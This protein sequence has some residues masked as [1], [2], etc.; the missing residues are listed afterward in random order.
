[1]RRS[2][3]KCYAFAKYFETAPA[4]VWLDLDVGDWNLIIEMESITNQLAQFRFGEVQKD[5]VASSYALLFPKML[6]LS[7]EL[8]ALDCVVLG[9]P[10][11]MGNEFSQ[12]RTAENVRDFSLLVVNVVESVCESNWHFV[13][14]MKTS[15]SKPCY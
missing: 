3:Y 15:R 12:R 6:S 7:L 2:V 4:N 5:G 14:P 13:S 9:R 10:D 1:M 11:P 8:E